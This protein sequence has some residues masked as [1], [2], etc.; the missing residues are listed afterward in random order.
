[1]DPYS[2]AQLGLSIYSTLSGG[3]AEASAN[4][5]QIASNN[6][7]IEFL[8]DALGFTK[9]TAQAQREVSEDDFKFSF[10][11]AGVE[12]G[13]Q[14]EG[15]GRTM[16]QTLDLS[17]FANVGAIESE[18]DFLTEKMDRAFESQYLQLERTREQ[19]LAEADEYEIST[20]SSLENQKKLLKR[21]NQHLSKRDSFWEVLF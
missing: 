2:M 5:A 13:T 14:W 3:G 20:V 1:M 4:R 19:G 7:Q 6:I 18:M 16:E 8:N 12:S 9:D 10:E 11:Q 15:I 17:K 21:Q